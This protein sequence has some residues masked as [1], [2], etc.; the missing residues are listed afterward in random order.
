MCLGVDWWQPGAPNPWT[1]LI[2]FPMRTIKVSTPNAWLHE[3][4]AVWISSSMVDI[5]TFLWH[6]SP[7]LQDNTQHVSGSPR[8]SFSVSLFPMQWGCSVRTGSMLF[9]LIMC[10][11][12]YEEIHDHNDQFGYGTILC[13]MGETGKHKS[14]EQMTHVHIMKIAALTFSLL[15]FK[16]YALCW[17][18]NM[19]AIFLSHSF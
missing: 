16:A 1:F 11:P 9:T 7:A 12:W 13:F 6:Q 2:S 3:C 14:T 19:S 5:N 18:S 15:S 8:A 17:C 10:C 4:C